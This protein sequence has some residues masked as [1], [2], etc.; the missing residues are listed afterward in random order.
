MAAGYTK[1][2]DLGLVLTASTVTPD[3]QAAVDAAKGADVA[4]VCVST[5]SSEGVDR[6]SLALSPID[7]ALVSALTNAQPNTV[8][9][10]HNPGA[11]L[12]PWA[13]SA[14]A[15]LSSWFPGQEMGNAL[16]DVL[17]GDVN[18]SGRLPLTFPMSDTDT[19]MQTPEQYP[20]VNG[21]VTYTEQLLIGYRWWDA[22]GRTPLFPFGHGLSYTT[23]VYSGLTVDTASAAPSILVTATVTNTGNRSGT[24]IAQLY[25]GFPASAGEPPL[26]LR[27]FS[28]LSL[29]PGE[30]ALASFELSPHDISTWD[31]LS[32]SWQVAHGT[33]NVAVGASSRDLR[34]SGQF[35]V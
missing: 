17:W 28:D 2:A 11:V 34:L 16:A 14:G 12:M 1:V 15:V 5:P 26:V 6:A 35:Q 32:Y 25:I 4:V 22:T 33:F 3:F 7:D 8:V 10:L 27:G 24:E 13:S 23:F 30:Y 31:T 21:T 9:V 29:S 18:P 20:G 19:P